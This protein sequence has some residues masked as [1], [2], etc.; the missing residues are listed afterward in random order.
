MG[1]FVSMDAPDESIIH[2]EQSNNNL[3][4]HTM[5]TMIRIA[6]GILAALCVGVSTQCAP[7]RVMTYDIYRYHDYHTYSGSGNGYS[8]SY[9][10][11]VNYTPNRYSAR[12]FE[13][14]ERF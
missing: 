10:G 3:S 9:N 2:D 1:M 4:I 13:P 5:K 8:P 11:R 7:N 6:T 12:S 14:V